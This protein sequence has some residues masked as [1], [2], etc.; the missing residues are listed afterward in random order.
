MKAQHNNGC[1]NPLLDSKHTSSDVYLVLSLNLSVF[2]VSEEKYI[3]LEILTDK[4]K[5]YLLF[6]AVAA[7]LKCQ[8]YKDCLSDAFYYITR[9]PKG[10]VYFIWPASVPRDNLACHPTILYLSLQSALFFRKLSSSFSFVEN[11]N[12]R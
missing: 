6:I 11:A 4:E 7:F 12:L 5:S 3:R 1:T 8:T 10:L 9:F 2:V